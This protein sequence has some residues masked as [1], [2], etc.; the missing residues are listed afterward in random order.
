MPST[1]AVGGDVTL[2]NPTFI[3]GALENQNFSLPAPGVL[4]GATAPAGFTLRVHNYS[5]PVDSCAQVT[6]AANGSL[7]LVPE[8][9]FSGNCSFGLGVLDD[10]GALVQTTV[11]VS[12][13]EVPGVVRAA[14]RPFSVQPWGAHCIHRLNDRIDLE[15]RW[16]K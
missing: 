15:S 4:A 12:I 14:V 2:A 11:V 6:V 8:R 10:M 9:D 16:N 7:R 1:G 3:T 13:G 5:Q